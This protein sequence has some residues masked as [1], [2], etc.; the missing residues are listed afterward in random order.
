[1]ADNKVAIVTGGANGLGQA[2]AYK[3]ADQGI[4]ITVVDISE[5]AGNET[6]KALEE[7]GV[8]ALF[9]KADVSKA[10]DVK[11]Y[12]DQTVETFGK[13]DMFFNNA[14]ISGPGKRFADNTIEEIEQVVGINLL[15][16][17][18]G[19]KYVLEVMLKN[20][21]GAIVNT[22]STAGVVGQETVG[23]Y[24]ATKHGIVGITKTIAAEYAREGIQVNAIAPGTTETPMVAQY[25]KDHPENFKQVEA[26]IPQRRLGKPEEI[27]ELVAFLLNG[28]AKYINGVVV[29]IDGGFTAV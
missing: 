8:K 10:E 18:Y 26:S 7:K 20:G 27:A 15:G 4:N 23:T 24:S 19:I 6:V 2:V 13:I 11:N 1:M 16:G 25:R 28:E 5:E 17:L 29:P 14:G 21:D 9:V 12:V 22:S 3:L